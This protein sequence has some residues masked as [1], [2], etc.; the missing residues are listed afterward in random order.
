MARIPVEEIDVLVAEE[1]G[2]NKKP[3]LLVQCSTVLAGG[4]FVNFG[5][6]QF[7]GEGD[8]GFVD[9]GARSYCVVRRSDRAC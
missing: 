4:A 5:E 8:G 3:H 9:A 6:V 7:W 2:K 1:F